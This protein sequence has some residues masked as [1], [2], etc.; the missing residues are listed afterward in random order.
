MVFIVTKADAPMFAATACRYVRKSVLDNPEA[1]SRESYDGVT[2]VLL[3]LDGPCINDLAVHRW[4]DPLPS[5]AEEAAI[6]RRMQSGDISGPLQRSADFAK[7]LAACHG[8]ILKIADRYIPR[9]RRWGVRQKHK[10]TDHLFFEDLVAEGCRFLWRA[11]LR[12]DPNNGYRF[13]TFA[14]PSVAGAI[15]DAARK[16]RRGGAGE[17]RIDRWLYNYPDATPEQVLAAQDK[18]V[19][20]DKILHS[21]QEAAEGIKQFWAWRSTS[22]D[23]ST[24]EEAGYS[25]DI[26]GGLAGPGS[27]NYLLAGHVAR[28]FD[29]FNKYKL[30]PQLRL[31]DEVVSSVV[32][33][34]AKYSGGA[35]ARHSGVK[36]KKTPQ[37]LRDFSETA[38]VQFRDGSKRQIARQ[39]AASPVRHIGVTPE[40]NAQYVAMIEQISERKR[41]RDGTNERNAYDRQDRNRIEA[42]CVPGAT[43]ATGRG[44][45]RRKP[46]Y[47]YAEL[48]L[49]ESISPR[50]ERARPVA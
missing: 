23:H 31:H 30:S 3:R 2:K 28:L 24:T 35:L 17:S 7:I 5:A 18:L 47:D 45:S 44:T 16:W 1:E 13:W 10:H 38:L 43:T 33:G 46:R 8:H 49:P 37:D 9:Y 12:F 4:R 40:L 34:L 11:A 26:E 41:R 39:K 19:R 27:N 29:C 36:R 14:R 20:R 32:D 48:R 21:L 50:D 42:S 25:N 22:Q 15:A 6:I